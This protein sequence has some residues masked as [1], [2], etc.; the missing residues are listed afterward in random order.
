LPQ[1]G[2]ANELTVLLSASASESLKQQA[3]LKSQFV[4]ALLEAV[5]KDD[6]YNAVLDISSVDGRPP[7]YN[8]S[9]ADRASQG[10][11]GK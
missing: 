1:A 3:V 8:K 11:A 6:L 7:R 5:A 10:V 4:A 2:S 9:A